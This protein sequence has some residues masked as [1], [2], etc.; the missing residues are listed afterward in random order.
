MDRE[1]LKKANEL[2]DLIEM[3]NRQLT[4][5]E[6]LKGMSDLYI[7]AKGTS[8]ILSIPDEDMVLSLIVLMKAQYTKSLCEL[9]AEL[10]AL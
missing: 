2:S 4:S 9:Q 10:D 6:E 1:K 7:S 5:L 3:R 8:L